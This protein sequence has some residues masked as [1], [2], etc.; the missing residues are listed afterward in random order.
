MPAYNAEKYISEAI[1]SILNQTFKGFEFIIIDDCSTDKTWEIVQD[2][3]KKDDRVV[4][5]RNLENMNVS[6]TRNRGVKLSNGE[7]IVWADADDISLPERIETQLKFIDQNPDIGLCGS[8]IE[9]FGD[10]QTRSVRKYFQHDKELK[11]LIFR[12]NP[13]AQPA[14]IMRKEILDRVN[15]YNNFALSE[16]LDVFFRMGEV[17]K[18]GNVQK[19]LVRYRVHESSLTNSRLKE[20]ELST[21]RIRWHYAKSKFYNYRVLDLLFNLLQYL[22]IYLLPAKMKIQLFNLIRNV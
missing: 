6:F 4:A 15:G 8:F 21:L 19:I 2:F 1:E 13:I 11:D 7:Y 3:A 20:M 14:C 9:F 10:G 22:S 16:D 12:Q 17:S 18:F 5:F